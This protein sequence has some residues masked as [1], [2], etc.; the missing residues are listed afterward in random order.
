[1]REWF[2]SKR[3]EPDLRQSRR[4]YEEVTYEN[5]E[6]QVV[7]ANE[8]IEMQ[9]VDAT[10][11]Y[12]NNTNIIN[13]IKNVNDE[14]DDNDDDDKDDSNENIWIEED[15]DCEIKD[16]DI[17][18]GGGN[19]GFDI[20][21]LEVDNFRSNY[22][23][24]E[25]FNAYNGNFNILLD[26]KRKLLNHDHRNKQRN[27]DYNYEN[28]QLFL[29]SKYTFNSLDDEITEF[30]SINNLTRN[31]ES[32]LWKTILKFL[33]S[34][35]ILDEAFRR[36]VAH[37]SDEKYMDYVFL[38]HVCPEL[39]CC[40]FIGNEA[41]SF[42]C[43]KCGAARYTKCKRCSEIGQCTHVNERIPRKRL[44][45]NCLIPIILQLITQ[46]GFLDALNYGFYRYSNRKFN[47]SESNNEWNFICD[48][49]HSIAYSEAM[50]QIRSQYEQMKT[51]SV[52]SNNI[53]V[54]EETILVPL[55][56]SVFYDG[57]QV[58]STQVSDFS[59]LIG[60][61]NIEYPATYAK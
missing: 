3:Y 25:D 55:L 49:K 27:S 37:G 46:E 8:N 18:I 60:V 15:P 48:I 53:V 58:F 9:L 1:M 59:P 41:L 47:T 11:K 28:E 43:G 14:N 32:E 17:L 23:P 19:D 2:E 34:N 22:V 35:T 31:A 54:D 13:D 20:D 51:A 38:F 44:I 36:R 10:D 45:Y 57:V 5:I 16:S 21:I 6:M 56:F 61:D 26:I 39:N 29:G 24:S 4:N 7:D 42:L 50:Q 33:P 30:C 40:V 12:D 52:I